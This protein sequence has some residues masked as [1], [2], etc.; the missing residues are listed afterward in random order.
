MTTNLPAGSSWSSTT[1]VP[2]S[3]TGERSASCGPVRP[4]AYC[5]H[6]RFWSLNATR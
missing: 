5:R 4:V 1:V 2:P 3:V 6:V